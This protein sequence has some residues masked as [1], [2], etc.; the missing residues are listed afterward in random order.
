MG[1]LGAE[2]IYSMATHNIA[3]Q[4][5]L[6]YND[7]TFEYSCNCITLISTIGF[8]GQGT[9]RTVA[10]EHTA[11]IASERCVKYGIRTH[12]T[13]HSVNFVFNIRTD[14]LHWVPLKDQCILTDLV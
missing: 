12:T 3:M 1:G 7:C 10:S 11:Y 9:Y 5:A 8:N 4:L 2:S 14:R 6:H 13:V